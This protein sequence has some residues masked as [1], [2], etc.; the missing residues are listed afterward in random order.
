MRETA[1]LGCDGL[2]MLCFLAVAGCATPRVTYHGHEHARVATTGD[3]VKVFGGRGEAPHRHRVIGTV[4]AT[5][6]TASVDDLVAHVLRPQAAAVGGTAIHRVD[7]E[8]RRSTDGETAFTNTVTICGANVLRSVDAGRQMALTDYGNELLELEH[9]NVAVGTSSHTPRMEAVD[10]DG[11]GILASHPDDYAYFGDAAATCLGSCA[12]S[13]LSRA[14]RIAA[15]K[16]GAIAVAELRC[17]LDG[18]VS[19][20]TATLVGPELDSVVSPHHVGPRLASDE[21]AG[22]RDR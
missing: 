1:R 5:S 19:R 17:E 9:T 7:C 6:P 10:Q 14:I 8:I 3:D 20:C 15:A 4:V 21:P 18:A 13:T 12:R 22:P 11:V 16:R 2:G